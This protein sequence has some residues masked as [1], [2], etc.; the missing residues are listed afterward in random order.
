MEQV[1]RACS[2]SISTLG[3]FALVLLLP[4][5][6]HADPSQYIG[7]GNQMLGQKNYDGAIKYFAAAAKADPHNAAA[8]RGLGFALA[9][10]HD[11]VHG[12]QD[13]EYSLRLNPSDQGLR[14]YLGKIYQG[15]GNQYYKK[16]DQTH[17]M[18]WWN[19]AVTVDPGNTQ[20]SAYLRTLG[21]AA[22]APAYA[23][24]AQPAV[25]PK[26]TAPATQTAI[27]PTPGINPWIMGLS[28]ACLGAIMLF[29][30]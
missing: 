9:G 24:A 27:G 1:M 6:V 22:A 3:L 12:T 2:N 8:Y 21:G 28:V 26:S 23:G 13:M 14:Q 19:K 29:L 10:K 15:Y 18:A 7:W 4:A 16:G 11:L 30:F 17:A 20:L 25:S 5:L